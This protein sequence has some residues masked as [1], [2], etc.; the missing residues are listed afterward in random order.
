MNALIKQHIEFFNGKMPD[1]EVWQLFLQSK[2]MEAIGAL[3]GGLAHDFNNILGSIQ[4]SAQ[5]LRAREGLSQNEIE[6]IA[7]IENRVI[8]GAEVVKQLLSFSKPGQGISRSAILNQRIQ[9]LRR[10]LKRI[11]PKNI[12]ISLDLPETEY[13]VKMSP[14][15]FE[16]IMMNLVIN[17]R[18]AMPDGGSIT[19]RARIIKCTASKPLPFP[20]AKNGTYAKIELSDT[21]KGIEQKNIARI[22]DPYFSSKHAKGGT[23]LGLAIVYSIVQK[24]GGC[25]MVSSTPEKGTIFSIYLPARRVS[26]KKLREKTATGE[27]PLGGG[28]TILLVDDEPIIAKSTSHFLERYGYHTITASDGKSALRE[29]GKNWDKINLVLLDLE[30]PEMDGLECLKEMLAIKPDTKVIAMSGHFIQP[31]VW[32]PIRAGAKAFLQKPFDSANL[33]TA[34]R[35]AVDKR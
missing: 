13:S 22:F 30:L 5:C 29:F 10:L 19:I 16:Q 14:S 24:H 33:L 15:E 18:D 11:M 35:A 32:N 2:K 1:K 3:A 8:C 34:I 9:T 31:E 7:D 27:Q 17:A 26:V 25:I 20:D 23:G 6:A 21:G 12:N 4:A 28:E